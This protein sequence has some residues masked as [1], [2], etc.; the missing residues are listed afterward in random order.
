MGSRSY[1]SRL[2]AEGAAA[3]RAAILAAA[4]ELFVCHGYTGVTVAQIA[5]A[6]QVAVQTVYASAGG[7]AD[8][9]RELLL[10][11]VS[12]PH[13]EIAQRA[14]AATD[15]PREVIDITARGTRVAHELHWPTLAAVI[16]Q[17]PSEPAAAAALEEA[18][19]DYV[20]ALAAIVE[21][22]GQLSALRA[23]LDHPRAVDLLW[24]HLGQ[25]AWFSLVGH[26]RWSF[27]DAEEWLSAAAKRALLKE[28]GG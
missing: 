22:L 9:L 7:K 5:D 8:M 12:D 15:D 24:F 23:E 27:D 10:P 2:R 3:T 20:K 18:T 6:A 4:E 16:P 26:R 11:A 21:R 25:D 28:P 19:A 14:I 17:C 13:V 1:R